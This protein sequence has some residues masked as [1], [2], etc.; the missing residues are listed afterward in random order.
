MHSAVFLINLM[1][2]VNIVRPLVHLAARDLRLDTHILVTKEFTKRDKAGTWMRELREISQA[3]GASLRV[4]ETHLDA[5]RFLEGKGGAL[6]AASESNLSAHAE[7]HDIHR[8]APSSFLRI[9]LQH[10]FECV[11]FLQSRD[12]DLAHGRDVTFAADVVCAWC[13]EPRLT[14]L[15]SSQRGKL[16]VSGPGAVLQ[17]SPSGTKLGSGGTGLVCENLHSVRLNAAGDFKGGFIGMFEAFCRHLREDKRRVTLRPHP[18]GQYVLKNK[19]KL[20]ANVKLNNEPIYKVDL[21]QFAYGIS[22]PSSIIIDLIL[23]GVPVGVWRDEGGVMD[24]GNYRGLTEIRTLADWI[25]FADDAARNP[26]FYL[27]RQ[28]RFLEDQRMVVDPREVHARF[29]ELLRAAGSVARAR[30]TAGPATERVMFV[31]NSYVPTLQLSFV[32]PLAPLVRDREVATDLLTEEDLRKAF[33]KK[34]LDEAAADWLVTRLAEFRPTIIVFCRYSGPHADR[35]AQWARAN[36]VPALYHIDDDLLRIPPDIGDR[37]HKWHN[38][39][40]RLE[41]V[42]HLLNN[43]DLV[44]CSTPRLKRR[45]QELD[46]ATAIEVGDIYC[47]GNVL[48]PATLRQLRK[49]G[50]MAS[51]DHAHNL[52]RVLPAVTGWL[53]DNPDVVFELFGSIPKPA[54]L[55]AFGERIVTVPPVANYESFMVEFAKREWDVGICPLSPIEFNMFKADTKWVEYTSVGAAVIASRGT[56]YDESCSDGCGILADSVEE[57]REALQVL[58]SDPAR[59]FA[60]VSHAQDKLLRDYSTERLRAQVLSMFDRTKDAARARSDQAGTEPMGAS[61]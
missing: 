5:F 15:A 16:Y 24:I 57:W 23:A 46:V 11:G 51:A 61:S 10:G 4:L 32:K 9:T 3:T 33:G 39:P 38:D 58:T 49:V 44:Y 30:A 52:T 7:T 34:V 19:V 18:G 22:A 41:S 56:V 59:R 36:A 2:D 17:P 26:E 6:V 20:P 13:Q 60:I 55:E 29:A 45:I 50:Y 28:R 47:S 42:R 25:E 31:A 12:H 1:Q 21:R 40:L 35:M 48:R 37:K 43:V 14:S 8:F 27:A 54:E 53:R